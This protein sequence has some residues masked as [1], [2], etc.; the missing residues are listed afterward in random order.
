MKKY[1]IIIAVIILVVALG[2]GGFLFM[3]YSQPPAMTHETSATS[4]SPQSSN[5]TTASILGLLSGGQTVSCIINLPDNKGTGTIEVVDRKFAGDFTVTDNSGKQLVSHMIS[6]GTYV[7]AWSTATADGFKMK[8]DTAKNAAT[9]AQNN[10]SVNL[11]QK[12]DLKCSP[13]G[14]DNSKFAIP[15]NIKFTDMT[16]LMQKVMP[17]EVMP[18]N[19]AGAA[20]PGFSCAGITDPTAKTACENTMQSSGQ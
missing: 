5:A 19:T 15:T 3:K 6:D 14:V 10:Q 17:S 8:L 4:T 20:S 18:T 9:N 1:G 13:W 11:N 12:V 7:Y 16:D 2:V